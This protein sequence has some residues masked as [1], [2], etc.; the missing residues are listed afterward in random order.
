VPR[1]LL[2]CGGVLAVSMVSAADVSS[3]LTQEA[4]V[5]PQ[6]TSFTLKDQHGSW[7]VYGFPQET[8]R[9]VFFADSTGSEQLEDWIRPLYD[10]YQQ[11]IGFMASPRCRLGQSWWRWC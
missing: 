7:R 11:T 5:Y 1:L 10:R 9:V 8:V 3:G 2:C 4:H 6:A